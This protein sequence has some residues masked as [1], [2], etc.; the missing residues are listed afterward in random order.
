MNITR[1]MSWHVVDVVV[2]SVNDDVLYTKVRIEVVAA[3]CVQIH[4]RVYVCRMS[5][6]FSLGYW[7]VEIL[8]PSSRFEKNFI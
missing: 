1:D 5:K 7:P 3:N 2:V 6:R 8:M 4:T